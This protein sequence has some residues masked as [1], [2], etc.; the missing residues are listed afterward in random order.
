MGLLKEAKK[1]HQFTFRK[2]RQAAYLDTSNAMLSPKLA[3]VFE[4][5]DARHGASHGRTAELD[6]VSCWNSVELLLHPLD[7][8]PVGT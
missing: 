3:P 8:R 7:V 4:P 2:R 6:G 1:N 5:P